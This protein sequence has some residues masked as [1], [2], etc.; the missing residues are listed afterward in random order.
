ML[1]QEPNAGAG[2]CLT[3]RSTT[4]S[5]REACPALN[6]R[7]VQPWSTCARPRSEV[8]VAHL[9]QYLAHA[10]GVILRELTKAPAKERD[11]N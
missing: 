4:E 2:D 11:Q 9:V 1:P 8:N 3:I 5:R 7:R 10:P 6:D